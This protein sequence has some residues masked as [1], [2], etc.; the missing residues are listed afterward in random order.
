MSVG[1][2]HRYISK[3]IITHSFSS[4]RWGEIKY[5]TMPLGLAAWLAKNHAA[6]NKQRMH[7]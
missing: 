7:L 4:K 1:A 3:K 5:L 2:E 6:A